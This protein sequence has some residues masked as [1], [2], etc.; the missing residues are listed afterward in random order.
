VTSGFAGREGIQVDALVTDRYL[1]SLLAAHGRGAD[2]APTQSMPADPIRSI[3][4]RLAR[5]L[6][7]YHPSFRFEE[8]LAARLADVARAMRSQELRERRLMP[9]PGALGV[10]DDGHELIDPIDGPLR[11]AL[12]RPL[13]IGGALTSAAL[14]LVGVAFMAWRRAR[15]GGT[16]AI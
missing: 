10:S 8:T 16:R 3:A 15:A 7:R 11:P 2:H 5:E 9:L 6:P 1:D 12:G 14:S 13:L 4:D